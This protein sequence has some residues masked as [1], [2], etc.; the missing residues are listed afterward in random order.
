MLTDAVKIALGRMGRETVRKSKRNLAVRKRRKTASG[1]F[2]T[3][4]IDSSGKLSAS[5]KHKV[6]RGKLSFEMLYYGLYVD[7]GRKPGKYAP[8][9]VIRGWVKNK[10]VKLRD[11]LGRFIKISEKNINS[12]A[13]LINRGIHDNGILPT[14]FFSKPLEAEYRAMQKRLDEDFEKEIDTYFNVD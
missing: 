12:V 14:R 2:V 6:S 1:R 5:I 10:P 9:D 4:Q 8:V 3:S 11:K 7:E 13:F